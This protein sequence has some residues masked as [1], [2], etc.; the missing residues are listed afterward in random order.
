MPTPKDSLIKIDL[1][2]EITTHSL[3]GVPILTVIELSGKHAGNIGY[4]IEGENTIVIKDA[5]RQFM[6]PGSYVLLRFSVLGNP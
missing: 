5:I 6:D 3:M 1:P 4:S 2:P